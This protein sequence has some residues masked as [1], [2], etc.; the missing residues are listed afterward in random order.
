MKTRRDFL[1]QSIGSLAIASPLVGLLTSLQQLKAAE[2]DGEYKAIVC[3]LLEG[4]CDSFNMIAPREDDAYNNY[5]AVRGDIALNQD[6]LLSF[7][8]TNANGLNALAY[9]MRNNMT[10]M[11]Q[12]FTD[13]KLA[14]VANVGTL[15]EP[16]TQSDVISGAASVPS[17]LFSH[18]TQR[19]QWMRGNAKDIETSGWAGRTSDIFYPSANAYFNITAGGNNIMQSG[20]NVEAYSFKE[21]SISPNTMQH[22]GFGPEAGGSDLGTVYQAIYE[23]HQNADHKLFSTFAE[24]RVTELSH[25]VNLENLF[26]GVESFDDFTS[27]VHETGV[28]LGEQLEL[29]AQIL[30]VKDNFPGDKKRQIFFVNHHGWDTHD[31]DNE[32]QV[33][34]LNDSLSAFYTALEEMGIE[35]NVTTFTISDFGR[36]LTSN[37]EGT[38]HGWGNHAFVMGGAV[39]GGDIFGKMPALEKNSADA[40]SDRIIPTTSVDSYL[41]TIV[42]WFGATNDELNTIFPNL[43]SFSQ[44]NIGFMKDT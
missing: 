22:Y 34:Y 27:G 21:A 44:T 37:G 14:I 16:V 5:K 2:V 38:D 12:L 17:Q 36:S 30:S 10:E 41:A 29:I 43:Q 28:P 40:W 19:A 25:Q 39:K 32:H 1:K 24:K 6:D 18:N 26:D 42:K 4:G 7:S 20:G 8:H 3:V 23:K 35:N 13:Q 31:G 15:I 11:N 9:G 33:S